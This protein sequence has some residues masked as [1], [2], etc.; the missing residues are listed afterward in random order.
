MIFKSRWLSL[1]LRYGNR[2]VSYLVSK[3][4]CV[5]ELSFGFD[6]LKFIPRWGYFVL[7][8]INIK[9]K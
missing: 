6:G 3:Y 1:G 9:I 7:Y 4:K 5:M 2:L 8:L